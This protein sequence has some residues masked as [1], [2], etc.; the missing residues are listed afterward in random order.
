MTTRLVYKTE[1][2]PNIFVI[3]TLR[4]NYYQVQLQREDGIK[5]ESTTEPQRAVEIIKQYI[6]EAV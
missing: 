3:C 4:N 5:Y 1:V 6:Q 2:R